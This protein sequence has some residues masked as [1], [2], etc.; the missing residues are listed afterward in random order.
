M[1]HQYTP[2]DTSLPICRLPFAITAIRESSTNGP[3]DHVAVVQRAAQAVRDEYET[4]D[5]KR[6][7]PTDRMRLWNTSLDSFRMAIA[8]DRIVCEMREYM[9]EFKSAREFVNPV[10]GKEVFRHAIAQLTISLSENL[11]Q[12]VPVSNRMAIESGNGRFPSFVYDLTQVRHTCAHAY[13]GPTG[14]TRGYNPAHHYKLLDDHLPRL[15]EAIRKSVE[16]TIE[17]LRLS[18]AWEIVHWD[19][20]FRDVAKF[21][22]M[23]RRKAFNEDLAEYSMSRVCKCA[24]LEW[25]ACDCDKRIGLTKLDVDEE[26]LANYKDEDEGYESASVASADGD[27]KSDIPKIP[28]VTVG[29]H[30]KFDDN[31][32]PIVESESTCNESKQ[33]QMQSI[34]AA[35]PEQDTMNT[36]SDSESEHSLGSED[37]SIESEHDQSDIDSDAIPDQ[38]I[39]MDIESEHNAS[40][41]QDEDSNSASAKIPSKSTVIR[42]DAGSQDTSSSIASKPCDRICKRSALPLPRRGLPGIAKMSSRIQTISMRSRIPRRV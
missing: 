6:T 22:E 2:L 14:N 20:R 33:T 17:D 35:I 12:D 29:K 27:G 13:E 19:A 41:V 26:F 1:L 24:E 30:T 7:I 11:K 10:W 34:V 25:R 16:I 31:G 23:Q 4:E 32:L 39:E 18:V 38:H 42:W 36:V 37:M 5:S 3:P 21:E 15:C 28:G 8:L 9:R 40:Q